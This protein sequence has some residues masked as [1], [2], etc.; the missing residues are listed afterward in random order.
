MNSHLELIKPVEVAIVVLPE[1]SM[2]CVASV[3]DPLRAANRVA[4]KRLY[5]WQLIGIDDDP[6]A[7]TCGM[8]CEVSQRLTDRLRGD[9]MVV[10]GGFNQQ[11]HADT[12][13]L[14]KIRKSASSFAT[15]AGVE[16]GT[17]VLARAGLLNGYQ[18]TTHWEDFEAFA[19]RFPDVELRQDRFVTDRNRL[20]C[21][22]ASPA[23]DMTLAY[24]RQCHGNTIAAEVAS[25]FIY[26]QA[27]SQ[28]DAQPVF[29]LGRLDIRDRRLEQ[30]VRLMES[31]VENPC[32]TKTIARQLGVSCKTLE[33]IFKRDLGTTPSRFFLNLRLKLADRLVLNSDLDMREI[34]VRSGFSS[35]SAFSRA[36]SRQFGASARQRRAQGTNES[37]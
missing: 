18:A 17:W 15:I 10:I 23:F 28:Y 33:T 24:I 37:A 20:T 12:A 30:A 14:A 25:V 9:L 8:A 22:G 19:S 36:Y 16:A 1:S 3:L 34:S 26:E 5:H 35:L 29:S 32:S 4:G 6:V 7:L 13:D 31:S 11:R 21:G 2:L 27:R